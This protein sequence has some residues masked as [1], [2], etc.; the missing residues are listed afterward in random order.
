MELNRNN[1]HH[2]IM[3]GESNLTTKNI[4]LVWAPNLNRWFYEGFSMTGAD[5]II[6]V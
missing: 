2:K 4:K 3:A 6:T 5:F 1:K